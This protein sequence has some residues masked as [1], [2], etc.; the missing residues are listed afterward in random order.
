[1]MYRDWQGV[2][3]LLPANSIDVDDIEVYSDELRTS[4]SAR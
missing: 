2:I 3:T 1:M 4:V